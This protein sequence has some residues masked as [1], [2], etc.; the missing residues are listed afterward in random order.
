MSQSPSLLKLMENIS[1]L[2]FALTKVIAKVHINGN[3]SIKTCGA[4]QSFVKKVLNT[5]KTEI[6]ASNIQ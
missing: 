2:T 3:S 4:G 1:H 6:L 5:F